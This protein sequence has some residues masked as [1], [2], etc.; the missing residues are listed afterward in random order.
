MILEKRSDRLCF[1]ISTV[2]EF[3]PIQEIREQ[4]RLKEHFTW[5]PFAFNHE[6]NIYRMKQGRVRL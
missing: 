6:F 2:S 3:S 5:L 4:Q 1:R